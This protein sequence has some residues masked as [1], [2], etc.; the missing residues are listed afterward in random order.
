M[1]VTVTGIVGVEAVIAPGRILV[2]GAL[3]IAVVAFN[4]E[5]DG[6]RQTFPGEMN[7]GVT[8]DALNYVFLDWDGNLNVNTTGWP[9]T[10]HV[11][12]GRVTAANGLIIAVNDDR[13][14]LTAAI[15]KDV[16]SA[17]ENGQTS[18][19]DDVNWTQ[20]L[21]LEL[22][23][24]E[25]GTYVIQWYAEL[26]HSNAT[27]T[28]YA[29][30]RVEAND[31]FELGYSAWPYPVFEDSGGFSI[32]DLTAGDHYL[33]LD[34]RVQGGGTAYCRRARLLVWRIA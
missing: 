15:D 18:T 16:R 33:D 6:K 34:F 20:K 21:R 17:L 1:P 12:L 30:M 26:R 25:A 27:Q 4:L 29:E 14:L 22:N 32:Y 24:L 2:D 9:S 19:T 5:L 10:T 3:T 8:D 23:G 7:V 13:V 31:L 28:E 11:R